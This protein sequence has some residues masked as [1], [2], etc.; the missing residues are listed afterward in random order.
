MMLLLT[1]REKLRLGLTSVQLMNIISVLYFLF[2]LF[3]I[4]TVLHRYLYLY[5]TTNQMWLIPACVKFC[6]SVFSFHSVQYCLVMRMKFFLLKMDNRGQRNRDSKFMISKTQNRNFQRYSQ[7]TCLTKFETL[8]DHLSVSRY[9]T[10]VLKSCF[11]PKKRDGRNL[12][13]VYP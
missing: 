7:T 13:E 1:K 12:L 6:D 2:H 3:P 11:L 9:Y 4:F 10:E 8:C 5:I